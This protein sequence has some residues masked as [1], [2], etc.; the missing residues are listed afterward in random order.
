[1]VVGVSCGCGGVLD[2]PGGWWRINNGLRVA[3]VVSE[4]GRVGEVKA[5]G[6]RRASERIVEKP[7]RRARAVEMTRRPGAGVNAPRGD[8]V[9]RCFAPGCVSVAV[10][11]MILTRGGVMVA[12]VVAAITRVWM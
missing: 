7:W 2:A 4:R 12:V 5:S 10:A 8:V 3:D 11:R 9:V 6:G 1:V